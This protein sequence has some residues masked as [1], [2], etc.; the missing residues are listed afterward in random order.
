M[1]PY[2]WQR[3]RPRIEVQRPEVDPLVEKL[4]RGKSAVLL[5]GRGMGKSV[6]LR[7][8]AATLAKRDD[9]RVLLIPSPPSPLTVESMIEALADALGV[10]VPRSRS[11]HAL[12]ERYLARPGQ[13]GRLVLLYDELDRYGRPAVGPAETAPGR[14]FFNNLEAT[15]R[16]FRELGI[17]AAGSLGVF[18]FRD[19]L[20]SS[21]LA[22]ADAVRITT[23][24]VAE[25]AQLARPF[26]E[27][28]AALSGNT[29]EALLLSSGGNP[30]LLTY[31]LESIWPL[32]EA[33]ERDVAA[34]YAR[35]Q[36]E[37]KEFLRD[38]ELS[39]ADESLSQAPRRVWDL[40][41]GGRSPFSHAVLKKACESPAAPLALD[42]T[43]VLDLLQAAGL[44]RVQGSWSIDPVQVHPIPS[45]LS[46]P[47]RATAAPDLGAQ[48]VRDLE[49]LLGRIHA[50][51][52]DFFRPGPR[53]EGV[54][55]RLVPESVFAAHLA[56][57]FELLGWQVE[58]EAQ[59]GAGRTDL[60]LR[61]NGA[62][63][64][65][66]VEL[67][68]WGRPGYGEVHRQVEGYWSARVSAGAV[69]MLTDAE[70][71]DWPGAYR[72]RCLAPGVTEVET[73]EAE[74][75]P[76][77]A[78]LAWTSS[79]ADGAAVRVD[80]FLLGCRQRAGTPSTACVGTST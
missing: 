64:V 49:R 32:V 77:R 20:G 50:A 33:D 23:F 16:D 6:F 45:L 75:S 2:D 57:G 47:A 73:V 54:G 42:F 79:T 68:I 17:L 3:H 72:R 26:A 69:V 44:V 29:L 63:E 25:A 14:E 36:K 66:V 34:A 31:G 27:R 61:W 18:I 74:D 67:K 38:F 12:V 43:D 53:G 22:R 58:R 70:I 7:Q 10:E 24:G 80:H 51:A 15:R 41:R 35:F 56:L 39:F 55:K 48:L 13:P 8:L 19:V 11:T 52:A 65:A 21:F 28:G 60:K 5:A 30:A 78:R 71:D 40:I 9:L 62:S 37:N 59:H 76:V 4:S 1:N 46:L